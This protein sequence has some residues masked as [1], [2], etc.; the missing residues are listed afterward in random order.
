MGPR[1]KEAPIKYEKESEICPEEGV[2]VSLNGIECII[3]HINNLHAFEW[4]FAQCRKIAAGH[5]LFLLAYALHG[6][7][8]LMILCTVSP[9][10]SGEVL[11]Q[12]EPWLVHDKL[13]PRCKIC[14]ELEEPL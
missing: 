10:M 6:K 2:S 7:S 8:D 11:H 9:N 12:L 5:L 4:H 13:L 3:V 1:L 14:L